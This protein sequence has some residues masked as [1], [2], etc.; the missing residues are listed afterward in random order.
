M[1]DIS[2]YLWEL[3]WAKSLAVKSLLI[4]ALLFP[5]LSL[6]VPKIRP[7]LLSL[8]ITLQQNCPHNSQFLSTSAQGLRYSTKMP[9]N[10]ALNSEFNY[11]RPSEML[12]SRWIKPGSLSK[13]IFDLKGRQM[14]FR[15]IAIGLLPPGRCHL[16]Y[17]CCLIWEIEC[18]KVRHIYNYREVMPSAMTVVVNISRYWLQVLSGLCLCWWQFKVSWKKKKRT[19]GLLCIV[20][21]PQK[22]LFYPRKMTEDVSWHH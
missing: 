21:S 1:C 17:I 14:C 7:S 8:C 12:V 15:N 22:V 2:P 13:P 6:C 18:R 16:P 19:S 10:G 3:L 9:E 11:S 20:Q 4:Y 5:P